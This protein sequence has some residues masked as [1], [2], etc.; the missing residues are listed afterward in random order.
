MEPRDLPSVDA[1]ANELAAEHDLPSPLVT[2][3]A[4]ASVERARRDL[5]AGAASDPRSAAR[6]LVAGLSRARPQQVINATGVLLHTNLGRAPLA[7]NAAMAAAR[8]ATGYG[9]LEIDLGTGLRSKRGELARA[10]LAALTGAQAAL[11]VNNNAAAL[12]LALA[13]LVGA[14]R[15]VAVSRGEL[16]EIG[17]SFRLPELMNAAGIRLVEI[18]TTNRTGI[19]DY[20]RVVGYVD[21]LLKVHPANYRVEGFTEAATWREVADLAR[22]AGVP[23]IAD[24]GSG[25]LDTRVPWMRG[26]PPTWLAE[27][28]GV[29]QVLSD[30]AGVVLFSGDKLLGG[31]QSGLAVGAHDLIA[32][33]AAH[34]IARAVRL[35]GPT[36][37][38]LTATLTLY[39]EGRGAEVPFWA[40]ASAD[41]AELEERATR[42]I[43]R[44]GWPAVVVAGASLPGAGSVPGATI[45]SPI[46]RLEGDP[47]DLWRRLACA[48]P[49]ILAARR[50]GQIQI[51]LRT[52]HPSHDDVLAGALKALG[53]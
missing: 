35:D 47:D 42:L 51:D 34:P 5:I 10:T 44:A 33:M 26:G 50:G 29:R 38:A 20:E 8:Q 45:P 3:I 1:L 28:P 27:E 4:R 15:R 13:S 25:L 46:I 48:E 31:P 30:G 2:A 43:A 9:N 41:Y 49:P 22:T 52:V 12:L 14:G 11:A 39:A 6:S 53:G 37:A 18:G 24:V 23:F 7:E 36:L 19:G 17:G 16:I 32:R 21:A 40:M